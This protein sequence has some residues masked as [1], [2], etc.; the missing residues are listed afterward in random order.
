VLDVIR[1]TNV[2]TAEQHQIRDS[3]KVHL[4]MM[5]CDLPLIRTG[6]LPTDLRSFVEATSNGRFRLWANGK[7]VNPAPEVRIDLLTDYRTHRRETSRNVVG[8]G[9]NK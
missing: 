6:L 8:I 3:E 1:I 9:R 2:R 4:F 5:T 7:A